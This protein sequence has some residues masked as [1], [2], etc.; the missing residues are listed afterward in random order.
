MPSRLEPFNVIIYFLFVVCYIKAFYVIRLE[1]LN[2][3]LALC[4][5][6][7]LVTKSE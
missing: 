6:I 5:R 3:I 4:M 2:N 7:I 1:T